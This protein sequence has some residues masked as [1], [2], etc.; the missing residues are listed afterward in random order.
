MPWLAAGLGVAD[1]CL[2]SDSTRLGEVAD[3]P[4]GQP[5]FRVAWVHLDSVMSEVDPSAVAWTKLAKEAR[6]IAGF[7]D[8]ELVAVVVAALP[9]AVVP[10]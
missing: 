2:A 1:P 3:S 8:V 10:D 9:W 7:H 6:R 5:C 4:C